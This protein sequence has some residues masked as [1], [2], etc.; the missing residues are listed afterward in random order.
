MM[1]HFHKR[2]KRLREAKGWSQSCLSEKS[3]ISQFR[4][5]ILE[6]DSQQTPS[7]PQIRKLARALD[8]NS[9]YLASGEGNTSSF[10]IL[11]TQGKYFPESSEPGNSLGGRHYP[12]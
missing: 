1:E 2:L 6:S 5:S 12:N 11:F 10:S 8:T 7:W 3:Q 9:F 4:I